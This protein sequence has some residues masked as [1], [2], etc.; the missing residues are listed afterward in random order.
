M[1]LKDELLPL[2]RWVRAKFRCGQMSLQ[3]KLDRVGGGLLLCQLDLQLE[4][5]RSESR[6]LLLLYLA[7]RLSFSVSLS[8]FFLRIC[9]SKPLLP[10]SLSVSLTSVSVSFSLSLFLSYH[11]SSKNENIVRRERQTAIDN[12]LSDLMAEQLLLGIRL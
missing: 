7:Y 12:L 3:I 10:L 9:L 5:E 8:V 6:L 2:V 11:P 1:L 4:N